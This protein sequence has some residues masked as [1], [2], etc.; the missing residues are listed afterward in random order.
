MLHPSGC[1]RHL[2]THKQM[3]VCKCLMR[4]ASEGDRATNL[5]L[6]HTCMITE[7]LHVCGLTFK[8]DEEKA[9]G[10]QP[11]KMMDRDYY[12]DQLASCQ[13]HHAT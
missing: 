10:L 8:G 6:V 3:C 4:L 2:Q 5:S 12:Q 1:I 13:V 7:W 9:L 11:L